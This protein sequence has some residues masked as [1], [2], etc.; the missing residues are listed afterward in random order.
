[1][2]GKNNGDTFHSLVP[3]AEAKA[4]LG[5]DDRDDSLLGFLLVSGAYAIEEYCMRRLLRKRIKESF[6]DT[7]ETVFTLREYPVR[8]VS[9]AGIADG[10]GGIIPAPYTLSPDGALCNFP[11]TL[12]VFTANREAGRKSVSVKYIAGYL[13]ADVPP[14]LKEACLELTAWKYQRHNNRFAYTANNKKEAGFENRMPEKVRELLEPYRR[15][16]I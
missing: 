6:I 10:Y 12:R 7:V 3:L 14:D 16:T 1:M 11:Y 15:R 4:F 2:N 8:S 9:A 13:T 5:V